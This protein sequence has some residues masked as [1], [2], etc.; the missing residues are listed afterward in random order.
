MD[1]TDD[2]V[3]GY[4][5]NAMD[6]FESGDWALSATDAEGAGTFGLRDLDQAARLVWSL[7]HEIKERA[8]QLADGVS[9]AD[10]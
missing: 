9:S 3:P 7:M 8:A 2:D 5:R 6:C 4:S 1:A 10:R